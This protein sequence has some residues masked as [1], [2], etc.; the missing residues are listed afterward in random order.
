MSDALNR[1]INLSVVGAQKALRPLNVND[2]MVFLTETADSIND[3]EVIT[4]A[5]QVGSLYGTNSTA[6]KIADA[7]FAQD[8][9]IRMGNGNLLFCQLDNAVSATRGQLVTADIKNNIANFKQVSS[10]GFKIII[11][12]NEFLVRNLDFTGI[13]N[14][15]D[16]ASVINNKLVDIEVTTNDQETF[17]QSGDAFT[18]NFDGTIQSGD[19]FTSEFDGNLSLKKIITF[20]S[21]THG[22]NSSVVISADNGANVDISG[23]DYLNIANAT[24]TNG[25]NSSGESIIEAMARI[26]SNAQSAVNYIN[27]LTDLRMEADKVKETSDA[28]QAMER[29]FFYGIASKFDLDNIAD[30]IRLAGNANTAL[31]YDN[32][33]LDNLHKFVGGVVSRHA[34][35]NFNGVETANTLGLKVIRTVLPSDFEPTL[36]NNV[37]AKGVHRNVS[38]GA[39]TGII[40]SGASEFPD[41]I[42]NNFALG[43]EARVALFNVLGTTITAVR[44][45]QEGVD[46]LEAALTEVFEK[47]V[48][49]GVIGKGLEWNGDIF[50]NDDEAFR[51]SIRT[52]GYFIFTQPIS[53][54]S[55]VE[56]E[57]RKAPLIQAAYKLAGS[58]EKVDAILTFER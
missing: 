43:F 47:F 17:I 57:Q 10:G 19:A 54:Q 32:Q 40:Q 23:A 7:I 42:R 31:Y 14:I 18:D 49:N 20:T 48:T 28:I 12:G 39:R 29:Q 56:R 16:I 34:S 26:D 22:A 30:D 27:V 1:V 33:D 38:F 11:D 2:T 8:T 5:S 53:E 50:G 4:S 51:S 55:Q 9:T 45:T 41:I 15:N 24:T 35:V 13:N 21:R 44:Q 25:V 52:N 46:Q 37:E 36:S 6:K 58:I 3:F